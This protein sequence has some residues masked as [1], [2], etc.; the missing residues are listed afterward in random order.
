MVISHFTTQCEF[1]KSAGFSNIQLRC[2]GRT[3]SWTGREMLGSDLGAEEKEGRGAR[4]GKGVPEERVVQRGG[5]VCQNRGLFSQSGGCAQPPRSEG[6][7]RVGRRERSS[8]GYRP[9]CPGGWAV[10]K[11]VP[12]FALS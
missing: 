1:L 12:G 8:W 11:Q 9:G 3:G 6:S 10:R 4:D 5:G 2:A 7:C